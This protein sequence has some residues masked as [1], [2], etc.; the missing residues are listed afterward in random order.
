MSKGEWQERAAC[1][2]AD[3]EVF[4]PNLEPGRKVGD[5]LS[6]QVEQAKAFCRA[7]PVH[8]QCLELALSAEGGRAESLRFGVFGGLT[9]NER[10]ALR[11][12]VRETA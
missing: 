12:D 9:P 1:R 3:L 10:A 11:P 6:A 8:R 2:D 5:R 7:C 4:F